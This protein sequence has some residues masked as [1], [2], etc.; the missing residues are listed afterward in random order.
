MAG[1]LFDHSIYTV[2]LFKRG[3]DIRGGKDINVLRSHHVK[4]IMD[5]NYEKVSPTTPLAEIFKKIENSFES[6]FVVCDSAGHL[7]GVI[8]FQDIRSILS[9][10]SLDYL[11]IAQDLIYEDT[12]T[13]NFDDTLEQAYQK[14]N[15]KDL[16]LMPVLDKYHDNKVIGVIRRETLINYYNKQLI[17]TLRR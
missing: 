13:I 16:Q 14:F 9:Q 3:I 6:Y 1:K 8:S 11:I 17:D 12:D 15:V 5:E 10:H 2:K 4:E 7:N